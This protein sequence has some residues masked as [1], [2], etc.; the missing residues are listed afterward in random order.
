M[1]PAKEHIEIS[2]KLDDEIEHTL[3]RSVAVRRC[4]NYGHTATPVE[5]VVRPSRLP[6][7]TKW[8]KGEVNDG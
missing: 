8:Q 2:Q 7:I 4:L 3:H 1:L 5:Y 6:T